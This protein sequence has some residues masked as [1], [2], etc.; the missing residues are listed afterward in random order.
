MLWSQ[1]APSL[2]EIL[3]RVPPVLSPVLPFW[4]TVKSYL[5]ASGFLS[6]PTLLVLYPV[7]PFWF[8]V[9]SYPFG[10]LSSP[11]LLA[12]TVLCPVLPFWYSVQS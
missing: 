2:G 1:I 5:Y 8:S 9:Q 7:L 6:S 10:S 4:D 3:T 11:T 12:G